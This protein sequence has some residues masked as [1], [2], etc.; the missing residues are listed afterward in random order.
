MYSYVTLLSNEAPDIIT[1]AFDAHLLP[2][3]TSQRKVK[4]F[5]LV[6]ELGMIINKINNSYSL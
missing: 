3:V 6:L 1:L 4:N 2:H 5:I